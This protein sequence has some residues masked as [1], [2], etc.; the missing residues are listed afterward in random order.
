MA[1]SKL[2]RF[3][4]KFILEATKYIT[5]KP[6]EESCEFD[7]LKT[8]FIVSF[9]VD[10]RITFPGNLPALDKEFFTTRDQG[11]YS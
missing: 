8:G 10:F 3:P 2:E 9:M 6:A 11:T 4:G 1:D 7:L 5:V